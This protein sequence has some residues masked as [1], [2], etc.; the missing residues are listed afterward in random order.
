MG[1]WGFFKLSACRGVDYF[2]AWDARARAPLCIFMRVMSL[3]YH[4]RVV[5]FRFFLDW[6][7]RFL[8]GAGDIFAGSRNVELSIPSVFALILEAGDRLVIC[9]LS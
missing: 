3:D 8:H 6:P 2:L 5:N 1:S 7:L 9:E 4:A